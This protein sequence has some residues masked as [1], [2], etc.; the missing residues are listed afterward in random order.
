MVDNNTSI[1]GLVHIQA[2]TT[3]Y[4]A[5]RCFVLKSYN[6]ERA[7]ETTRKIILSYNSTMDAAA[8]W[9]DGYA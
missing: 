3:V 2:G 8:A 5:E 4:S 9:H 7:N 1:H 6:C